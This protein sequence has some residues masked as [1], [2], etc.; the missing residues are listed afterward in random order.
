M[1][2][3]LWKARLDSALSNA[4]RDI[5][6]MYRQVTA[7]TGNLSATER[8][9]LLGLA[10]LGIFYLVLSHLARRRKGES[11]DGRFVGLLLVMMALAAGAGWLVSS[12][13]KA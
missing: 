10:M 7:Y 5:G 2:G 3:G 8:L 11:A 9:I 4:G 1:E 6:D 12:G 13:T